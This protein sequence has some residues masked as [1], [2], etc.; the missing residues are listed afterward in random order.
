MKM[1]AAFAL[2]LALAAPALAAPALAQ[3]PA[4]ISPRARAEAVAAV[5]EAEYFD[6]AK[7]RAIAADLRREAAAG[8]FD[9]LRDPR[10]FAGA[11]T[12]RLRP[13]DGHFAVA[14]EPPRA[15]AAA[16][17]A[18]DP[19]AFEAA[20]RRLNHGFRAV[21]VLP[22]NVGYLDMRMFGHFE[23]G[24]G[25]AR[26]K[27]DAAM[28]LLADA[29]AI[30]VDLRDNGGGSPA[31]VGYL[32][33]YFVPAGADI[34]NTFKSR[35]PDLYERPTAEVRGERRLEAPLYILTSGR[36][37]SAAESF[38]YT[39]QAAKRA[40]VVGEASAG[41]ANPGDFHPVGEGL[42]VFVSGGTPI[43][44][45]TK[46][47]WEGT[48]VRPDVAAPAAE[49]LARAQ[50]L[51]LRRLAERGQP[52]PAATETR[53]VLEA[54]AAQPAAA[55]ALQAYAGTYGAYAVAVEDGALV[56][57]QGRRPAVRL[58]PLGEGLFTVEGAPL[59]RFLFEARG[60]DGA[61]AA[62]VSLSPDGNTARHLRGAVAAK[63]H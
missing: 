10:D 30:I 18:F 31:M 3:T 16:Q 5:I 53:W 50:G 6:P 28:A 42:R 37:A 13:L 39:L 63:P 27:A 12:A 52:E 49:A 25:P 19:A 57:R 60:A 43:N 22:G 29:D 4:P 21:E 38:T 41:G 14:W 51:A 36:T 24:K 62:L 26:D 23:G 44:P 34:Y 40:V 48:G 8:A 17:P 32:A 58:A 15:G 59:R 55:E 7:A 35:G 61:P 20:T 54:L 9:T 46:A 45:I 33:S 56:L 11:L 1:F 47:N 2:S